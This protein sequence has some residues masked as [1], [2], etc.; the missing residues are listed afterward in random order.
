MVPPLPHKPPNVSLAFP[1]FLS[2]RFHPSWYVPSSYSAGV[3]LSKRTGASSVA[4]ERLSPPPLRFSCTPSL[5]LL[6]TPCKKN[7][8]VGPMGFLVVFLRLG[9]AA[10]PSPSLPEVSLSPLMFR[11]PSSRQLPPLLSTWR[12]CLPYHC[13]PGAS[14]FLALL[15]PPQNKPEVH[16]I[17]TVM[18]FLQF[19]RFLCTVHVSDC[20]FSF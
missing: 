8:G 5:S 9:V 10:F 3:P 16:P 15:A 2:P 11:G 7:P 19:G 13:E 20:V 1:T 12:G 17:W 18:R 6:G 4:P 14:P